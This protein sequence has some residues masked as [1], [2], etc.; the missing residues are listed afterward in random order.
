M[1]VTGHP[2]YTFCI[3]SDEQIQRYPDAGHASPIAPTFVLKIDTP[4]S[5]N[6]ILRNV[7]NGNNNLGGSHLLLY[8]ALLLFFRALF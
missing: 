8:S 5:A 6:G 2:S 1:L 4:N 3:L 7:T